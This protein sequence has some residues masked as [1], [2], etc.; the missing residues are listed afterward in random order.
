MKP[1]ERSDRVTAR[2]LDFI[3][4]ASEDPTENVLREIEEEIVCN[5]QAIDMDNV[6]DMLGVQKS[7]TGRFQ[8]YAN[9]VLNASLQIDKYARRSDSI[10]KLPV[11]GTAASEGYSWLVGTLIGKKIARLRE[12]YGSEKNVPEKKAL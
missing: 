3:I 2:V 11:I 7:A 1:I 10:M 9:E 8:A 6:Y 12:K 5:G 4:K